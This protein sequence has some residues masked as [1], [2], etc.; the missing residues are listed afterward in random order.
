MIILF[1]YLIRFNNDLFIFKIMFYLCL[2][3]R[4]TVLFRIE[5]VVEAVIAMLAD[6]RPPF[7]SI[8]DVRTWRNIR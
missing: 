6:S 4:F 3:F 1:L 8:T 7:L 5:K 2:I